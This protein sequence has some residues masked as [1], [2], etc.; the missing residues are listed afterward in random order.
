MGLNQEDY[1]QIMPRRITVLAE[2]MDKSSYNEQESN[3]YNLYSNVTARSEF[4][5]QYNDVTHEHRVSNEEQLTHD[6]Q[7]IEIADSVNV[8]TESN[9]DT[10]FDGACHSA[11]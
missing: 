5:V 1:F 9:G 2:N 3:P 7:E 11:A 10:E 4:L 8:Y 6:S